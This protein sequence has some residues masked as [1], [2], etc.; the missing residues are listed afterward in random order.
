MKANRRLQ[1]TAAASKC[2]EFVHRAP[3]NIL[4]VE[5]SGSGVRIHADH[6]NFSERDKEFFVRHLADEGFIPDRYRWTPCGLVGGPSDIEWET[7]ITAYTGSETAG[8]PTRA[9]TAFVIRLLAGALFLWL[10]ELTSLFV[11]C[12]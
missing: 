12:K 2:F 1:S 9:A 8:K 11:F 3:Y 6:D 5:Q 7:E 10:I 4:K